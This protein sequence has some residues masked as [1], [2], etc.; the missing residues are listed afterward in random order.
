MRKIA[1]LTAAALATG[2]GIGVWASLGTSQAAQDKQAANAEERIR[3]LKIDLPAVSKPT[4]TLVNSV[5]VGGMLYVS[6]TGPGL[7]D[8]SEDSN[9]VDSDPHFGLMFPEEL[10]DQAKLFSKRIGRAH[11]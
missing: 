2:M 6:G 5:R 9:V 3:K 10:L 1:L 11:V 4:N 7:V 8:G